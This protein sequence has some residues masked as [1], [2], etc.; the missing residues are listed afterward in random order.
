MDMHRIAASR[1]IAALLLGCA[2]ASLLPMPA[3]ARDRD[4]GIPAPQHAAETPAR[5]TKAERATKAPNATNAAKAK[6]TSPRARQPGPRSAKPALDHSGHRRVG[7][8]S[9]YADRFAGRK[10]ADGSLMAHHDDNAA[11]RTLPLGTTARVTNLKTGQ[12]AVVTIQDRG[13]YAKGRIIDLSRTTARS[14]GIGRKNGVARV[15]VQPLSVPMPD[16]STKQVAP[17][18]DVPQR[19]GR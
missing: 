13:P 6:P 5:P 14:I 4:A 17:A 2:L 9:Y 15:A 8:A 7:H 16:G 19:R 11:S 1:S 12:S 18:E 3:T 10:M